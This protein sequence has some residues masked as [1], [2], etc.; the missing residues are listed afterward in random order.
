M[1]HKVSALVVTVTTG[2][3]SLSAP[4]VA[5]AAPP[6]LAPP[7]FAL[8]QQYADHARAHC[9]TR[10]SWGSRPIRSISRYATRHTAPP[11]TRSTVPAA[12]S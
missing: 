8:T 11:P 12:E 9:S 4:V 6:S 1:K 7:A 5:A 3:L 10:T 2:L